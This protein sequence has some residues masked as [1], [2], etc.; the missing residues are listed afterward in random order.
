MRKAYLFFILLLLFD[1]GFSQGAKEMNFKSYFD[2]YG[3]D[4][5]FVLYKQSENEYIRYNSGL[6]DSGYLP[7]STF[8]IPNALIALEEGVVKDTSQLIRWDGTQWP[9]KSWNKNQTLKTAIKNSVVW[10]FTGFADQIGIEKYYQYVRLFE[11]G[12]KDLT[13]PP[14]RFWLV[15]QLRISADQ[16][17]EFLKKFYSYNLPVS[18][19]SIDIVKDAIILEKTDSYILSG[20]TGGTMLSENYYIMWLVGYVEQEGKAYFY[21]MNFISD[22]F[23]KTSQARYAITKAILKDLGILI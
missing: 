18:R 19:Q 9:V 15:G 23:E 11:Y 1:N 8:K 2:K 16:Q 6:C 5:C 17:I 4:G 3:V 10:V 22:N 20:K 13:G 12:N 7:A 14:D 21:T